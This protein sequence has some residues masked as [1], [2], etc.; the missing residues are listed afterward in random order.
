MYHNLNRY[1]RIHSFHNYLSH[2]PGL[3]DLTADHYL[4]AHHQGDQNPIWFSSF[5]DSRVQGV[6][7][8]FMIKYFFIPIILFMKNVFRTIVSILVTVSTFL[9]SFFSFDEI[10]YLGCTPIDTAKW[11]LFNFKAQ[12]PEL[13]L[14]DCIFIFLSKLPTCLLETWLPLILIHSKPSD[15]RNRY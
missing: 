5:H 14:Q 10:V 11:F 9:F 12:D 4:L 15:S 2:V 1:S 7:I 3:M 13:S 8:W 6:F